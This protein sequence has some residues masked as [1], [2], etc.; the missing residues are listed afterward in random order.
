MRWR[1]R[2]CRQSCCAVNDLRRCAGRL[3]QGNGKREAEGC[4]GQAGDDPGSASSRRRER[5]PSGMSKARCAPVRASAAVASTEGMTRL[6]RQ[7]DRW[8]DV[9]VMDPMR[10][11]VPV[12]GPCHDLPQGFVDRHRGK[13]KIEMHR[14]HPGA[15]EPVAAA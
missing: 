12:E 2:R 15:Q 10:G 3:W 4:G 6:S 13:R 14:Y 1:W 11:L 9:A 8:P 7:H 5:L